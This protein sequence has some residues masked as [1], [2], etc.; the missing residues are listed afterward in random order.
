MN[1]WNYTQFLFDQEKYEAVEELARQAYKHALTA[2]ENGQ[3]Y[4]IGMIDSL[5]LL[6]NINLS[7]STYPKTIQIFQEVLTLLEKVDYPERLADTLHGISWVYFS[8]GEIYLAQTYINRSIQIAETIRDDTRLVIALNTSGAIQ[9]ET[10][11]PNHAVT[12]LQRSLQIL[13]D[14]RLAGKPNSKDEAIANNN[15]AMSFISLEQITQAEEYATRSLQVISAMEN[16]PLVPYS[17]IVDT[18]GLI[19]KRKGDLARAVELFRQAIAFSKSFYKAGPEIEHYLHLGEVLLDLGDLDPAEHN[20]LQALRLAELNDLHRFLFLCHEDLSRLHQLRGDFRLALEQYQ[21]FHSLKE[22]IYNQENIQRLATLTSAHQMESAL[23]DAE[24]LRLK[25]VLLT[26][27]IEQ[28]RVRY[29]ELE[30]LATSD[31]LTGLI[32]RRHFLTLGTYNVSY[33][34]G[35]S[36]PLSIIMLDVDNFKSINDQHGHSAGDYALMQVASALIAVTRKN[37]LCCRYGGD[38]FIILL[39]DLHLEDSLLIANRLIHSINEINL[40]KNQDILRLTISAGVA[41]LQ[42]DDE[43]LE[44]LIF[45]AD[46]A[47]LKAKT[48]GRNR[49][50]PA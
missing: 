9:A 20:L 28:A 40:Q 10:S 49:A 8:I 35:S 42:P 19:C 50:L 13:T 30:H 7:V 41:S 22:K 15:L 33:A 25:N 39:P 45:R 17:N 32:N 16:P 6:G 26:Q 27:E 2:D 44:Q 36:H 24:I 18:L 23:K 48:A 1:C 4:I 43:T 46:Q 29:D 34:R 38:E 3:P 14:L 31:S 11:N 37:D 12:T 5:V 47:L 21:M